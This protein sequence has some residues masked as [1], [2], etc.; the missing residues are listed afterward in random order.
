MTD[1]EMNAMEIIKVAGEEDYF[2]NELT[3]VMCDGEG[4]PKSEGVPITF[5]ILKEFEKRF[6]ERTP[7][8]GYNSE[9]F[10][11]TAHVIVC[12]LIEIAKSM[13]D[14]YRAKAGAE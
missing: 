10:R 3:R 5:A 9:Q 2:I 14:A 7:D 8:E 1:V 13:V 4:V 11:D 12:E 6:E